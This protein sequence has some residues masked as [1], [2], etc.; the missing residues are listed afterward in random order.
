MDKVS[1]RI[2]VLS[3]LGLAVLGFICAAQYSFSWQSNDG[4]FTLYG[5][6]IAL[7]CFTLL[8]LAVRH[9][10]FSLTKLNDDLSK[11]RSLIGH[12]SYPQLIVVGLLAGISEEW[13][14]RAFLQDIL[15]D[16]LGPTTL[17]AGAAIILASL[18]FAVMHGLSKWYFIFTFFFGLSLG[19]VYY[20]SGSLLLVIVWHGLYDVLA[21]FWLK[22]RDWT[23]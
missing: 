19:S 4:L 14:F 18:G 21:L 16:F 5:A 17:G 13:F 2:V 12:L 20:L 6:L 22:H 9:I 1:F 23:I 11:Y 15:L 8:Y 3:Q 7:A 10:P